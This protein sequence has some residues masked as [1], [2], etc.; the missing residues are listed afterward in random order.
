MGCDKQVHK[1]CVEVMAVDNLEIKN[2][3]SGEKKGKK[4][5]NR[6]RKEV[7]RGL[8]GKKKKKKKRKRGK[9]NTTATERVWE[10][11]RKGRYFGSCEI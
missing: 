5:E 9:G 3:G 4:K 6:K 8:W 1:G 10:E 7:V 2:V 11:N